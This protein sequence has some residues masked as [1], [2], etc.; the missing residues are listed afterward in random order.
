V[1]WW[2]AK[3]KSSPPGVLSAIIHAWQ[4]LTV[5]HEPPMDWTVR[6]H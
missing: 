4:A 5:Y 2:Q 3:E 1:V 6:A